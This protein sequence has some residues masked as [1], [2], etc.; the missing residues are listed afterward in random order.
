MGGS[1]DKG[2]NH[3][4]S[5]GATNGSDSENAEEASVIKNTTNGNSCE[6]NGVNG[7]DS[8]ASSTQSATART[9]G[10]SHLPVPDIETEH[11]SVVRIQGDKGDETKHTKA[12]DI[13]NT[14]SSGSHTGESAL[15][16]MP[17][18]TKSPYEGNQSAEIDEEQ[19]DELKKLM[20]PWGPDRCRNPILDKYYGEPLA[21]TIFR[22]R[23]E[24]PKTGLLYHASW[25]RGKIG[26]SNLGW[27]PKPQM[28]LCLM[29]EKFGSATDSTASSLGGNNTVQ[30]VAKKLECSQL[31]IRAMKEWN[32][33]FEF[34]ELY[35]NNAE[36]E[37]VFRTD[38]LETKT[39]CYKCEIFVARVYAA[40]VVLNQEAFQA[41]KPSLM[42]KVRACLA[43]MNEHVQ[44]NTTELVRIVAKKQKF[45]DGIAAA[46][47]AAAAAAAATTHASHRRRKRRL[48]ESTKTAGP[49]A[50]A[51]R[52]RAAVEESALD[53]RPRERTPKRRRTYTIEGTCEEREEILTA[54]YAIIQKEVEKLLMMM[55]LFR[56]QLRD[57]P[58]VLSREIQEGLER[59]NC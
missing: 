54:S 21:S 28:L 6:N 43:I 27:I 29:E 24:I 45:R 26:D 33:K 13:R 8:E 9:R 25:I 18:I 12:K 4:A 7:S 35:S 58:E 2:N 16:P 34:P 53:D 10:L 19:L 22:T 51:P 23:L 5:Q 3:G 47:A 44:A 11:P 36:K 55:E 41:V 14:G 20:E 1:S 30:A 46:G 39:R 38:T 40:V 31:V 37:F 57:R 56:Q 17:E 42:T 15:E 32:L 49:A 48:A 52:K 50:G 59:E